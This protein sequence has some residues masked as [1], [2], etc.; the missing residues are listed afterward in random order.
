MYAAKGA[1]QRLTAEY[2]AG[3]V[4]VDSENRFFR[5][6]NSQDFFLTNAGR[7][8]R[9]DNVAKQ[10]NEYDHKTKDFKPCDGLNPGE[11]ILKH[12][13]KEDLFNAL[14]AKPGW[15]DWFCTKGYNFGAA[16]GKQVLFGVATATAGSILGP[17]LSR[18]ANRAMDAAGFTA[19][20]PAAQAT[21]AAIQ[22]PVAQAVSVGTP[23][24]KAQ[25]L[26][27][28]QGHVINAKAQSG[29][30]HAAQGLRAANRQIINPINP[31]VP[32]CPVNDPFFPHGPFDPFRP[33]FGPCVDPIRPWNP[34][35]MRGLVG[36][37][38]TATGAVVGSLVGGPVGGVLGGAVGAGFGSFFGA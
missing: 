15:G 32:R 21:Q 25:G 6:Q 2:F 18:G 3:H 33:P 16:A 31:P 17:V 34:M 8:M 28:I 38:T 14:L 24:A 19:A 30:G 36:G 4:N 20:Q 13:K 35:W 26:N 22:D 10:Y 27:A 1:G 9:Y 37:S 11:T 12:G 7:I 29:I 23:A 5:N